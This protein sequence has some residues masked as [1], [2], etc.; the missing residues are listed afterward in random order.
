[1][2]IEKPLDKGDTV[3]I[4]LTSGEELLATYIGLNDEKNL[5]V[6]KPATISATPDGKMGVIPWMM[7]SMK[8]EVVLNINTVVT[9]APTVDEIAKSYKQ[10]VTNIKLV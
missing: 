6:E 3:T 5:V 7:T 8:E 10:S 4:K 1:M 2:L 9:F